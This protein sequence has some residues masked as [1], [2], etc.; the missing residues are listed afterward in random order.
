MKNLLG[1]SNVGLTEPATFKDVQGYVSELGAKLATGNLPGD[2]YQAMVFLQERLL[3]RMEKMARD[4]GVGPLMKTAR[5]GYREY[6]QTFFDAIGSKSSALAKALRE[7][8]PENAIPYLSGSEDVR[9]IR[10]KL[11][12]FDPSVGGQGGSAQLYDNY[13]KAQ[14]EYKGLPKPTELAKK[15]N[16]PEAPMPK[17]IPPAPKQP[18]PIAPKPVQPE[19]TKIGT[20]ELEAS[21]RRSVQQE[22]NTV[23]KFGGWVIPITIMHG[24]L[25]VVTLNAQVALS[26]ILDVPAYLAGRELFSRTLEKPGVQ[27][28]ISRPSVGDIRELMKLPPEYRGVIQKQVGKLAAEAQ[29]QGVPVS[30]QL[31]GFVAGQQERQQ[32]PAPRKKPTNEPPISISLPAPLAENATDAW[33]KG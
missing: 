26:A 9:D 27:D 13:L 20:A 17:A 6:R 16:P 33:Q 12:Q 7:R 24:V 4:N 30:P 1:E 8:L 32:Q 10:T 28:W 29:R 31:L 22:I 2:V 14:R 11:A 5:R 21:K 3:D 15:L 25:G 18:K 23:D 19:I